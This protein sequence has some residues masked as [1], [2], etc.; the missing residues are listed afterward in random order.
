M[1]TS[2]DTNRLGE[3]IANHMLY[4]HV[5]DLFSL[6]RKRAVIVYG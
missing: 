5:T 3:T 6:T 2:K 1:T 4:L